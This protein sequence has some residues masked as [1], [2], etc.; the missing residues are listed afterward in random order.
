MKEIIFWILYLSSTA[1]IIYKILKALN[2]FNAK[3]KKR[4]IDY[5]Y[6]ELSIVQI[7][8]NFDD[9]IENNIKNNIKNLK[10]CHFIFILEKNKTGYKGILEN[11]IKSQKELKYEIIEVEKNL[12][13]NEKFKEGIKFAKT[14]V[15]VLNENIEIQGSI[16]EILEELSVKEF[17]VNGLTY[18]TNEN[19]AFTGL[20][21]AFFNWH[22]F[23]AYLALAEIGKGK[24]VNPIF[25]ASKTK[26]FLD[27]E[28][29]EKLK[30]DKIDGVEFAKLVMD[31]GIDVFQS[32]VLGKCSS[33]IKN[34]IDFVDYIGNEVEDFLA[35]TK[36]TTDLRVYFLTIVPIVLPSITF[37]YSLCIGINYLILIS[38]SLLLKAIDTYMIKKIMIEKT[39]SIREIFR[40]V[41]IDIFGI[42]FIFFRKSR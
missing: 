22:S 8:E 24:R 18:E 12:T 17:I 16:S 21:E 14:F 34:R 31:E 35:I 13:I 3:F 39:V 1:V 32:R 38:V 27:Y 20:K 28:I 5:L 10:N 37:F 30:D 23:F 19:K 42:I 29:L 41:F 26:T 15:L 4:D 36:D 11:I 9:F 40:E 25:F 7:I 2:Y 33:N 6:E